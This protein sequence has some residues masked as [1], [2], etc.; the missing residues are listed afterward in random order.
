MIYGGNSQRCGGDSDKH[1]VKSASAA[2]FRMICGSM[3]HLLNT[4]L[5]EVVFLP[6]V[7]EGE[8]YSKAVDGCNIA[9]MNRGV[10][11]LHPLLRVT[12]AAGARN[13]C[14]GFADVTRASGVNLANVTQML[15]A[16]FA[17]DVRHVARVHHAKCCAHLPREERATRYVTVGPL[18]KSHKHLVCRLFY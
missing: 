14:V 7:A 11:K 12:R 5:A 10:P 4:I 9:R 15:R 1:R 3:S 6:A 18:C 2:A 16:K 8:T 13:I 17:Y